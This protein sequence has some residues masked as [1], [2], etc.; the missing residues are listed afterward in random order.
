MAATAGALRARKCAYAEAR[1]DGLAH[2]TMYTVFM[3][4]HEGRRDGAGLS[5]HIPGR[6]MT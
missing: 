5:T 4:R 1:A 2:S 6:E 3:P